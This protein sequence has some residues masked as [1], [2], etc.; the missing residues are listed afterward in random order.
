MSTMIRI[1]M[2]TDCTVHILMDTNKSVVCSPKALLAVLTDPNTFY[3]QTYMQFYPSTKE[4]IVLGLPIDEMPGLTLLTINHYN[5]IKCTGPLLFQL[6]NESIEIKKDFAFFIPPM[7]LQSSVANETEFFYRLFLE[8]AQY[9]IEGYRIEDLTTYPDEL[10]FNFM[11]EII[12]SHFSAVKRNVCQNTKEALEQEEVGINQRTPIAT[13]EAQQESDTPPD[14][15]SLAEY[16][17]RMDRSYITVMSWARD[18]KLK[19]ARKN[20]TGHWFISPYDKPQYI[21][22]KR[23]KVE[24]Q[25][26]ASISPQNYT[27]DDLQNYIKKFELLSPETRPYIR[28]YEELHYYLARKYREVCWDGFHYLIIDINLEYYSESKQKTNRELIE[29]GESPVVPVSNKQGDEDIFHL[30]HIGQQLDSP[31]AI[32]PQS[33]HIGHYSVFHQKSS[34]EE[35]HDKTF[36]AKRV[37]FWQTY[38]LEYEAAGSYRKIA[39]L[40]KIGTASKEKWE[41]VNDK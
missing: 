11:K 23:P 21:K 20:K 2:R 18:G 37:A 31:L 7:M 24:G 4:A 19:T 16:A 13:Q 10:R 17:K 35:K 39:H 14:Y 8:L 29:M 38:L 32:V 25:K 28:S 5:E 36:D 1:V 30:H 26:K 6:L 40:N 22:N 9:R 12:N 41:K 34:G 15:I 27:F 3:R 33:D